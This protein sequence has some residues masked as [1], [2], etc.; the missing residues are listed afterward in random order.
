M[1]LFP[2]GLAKYSTQKLF[3]ETFILGT[4]CEDGWKYFHGTNACYKAFN[5]AKTWEEAQSFCQKQVADLAS[6]TDSETNT[7]S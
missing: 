1:I 5:S 3:K 2:L 4:D 6:V 7:F